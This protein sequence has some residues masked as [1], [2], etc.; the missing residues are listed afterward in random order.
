[1]LMLGYTISW[2]SGLHGN[3]LFFLGWVMAIERDSML[4]PNKSRLV[5]DKKN[6]NP[7]LSNKSLHFESFLFFFVFSR[8]IWLL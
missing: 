6:P 7:P 2:A 4:G 3:S 1:M 5:V 8:I